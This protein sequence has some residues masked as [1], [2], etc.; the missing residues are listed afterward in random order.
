LVIKKHEPRDYKEEFERQSEA[1]AKTRMKK[2]TL[3]E[4]W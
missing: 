2:K 4:D 3:K 1:Q